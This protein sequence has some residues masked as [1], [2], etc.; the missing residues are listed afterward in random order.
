ML[1][2]LLLIC[3]ALNLN[4]FSQNPSKIDYFK[5]AVNLNSFNDD[6]GGVILEFNIYN[7]DNTIG[8]GGGWLIF[9]EGTLSLKKYLDNK[10]ASKKY[11]GIQYIY[12]LFEVRNN[13]TDIDS[14]ALSSFD[15]YLY[16]VP[17]TFLEYKLNTDGEGA[18]VTYSYYIKFP[19]K[20]FVY[21]EDS[22][23]YFQNIKEIA[24]N[25]E[26]DYVETIKIIE[27]MQI[28]TSIESNKKR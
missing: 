8:Y 20:M 13:F 6:S 9:K 2:I 14:N 11:K 12:E 19:C 3:F 4:I 25:S 10:F 27:I 26:K 15:K 7:K 18:G 17:L 22:G 21:R 16:L 5:N 24:I 1:K 28:Q 23:G